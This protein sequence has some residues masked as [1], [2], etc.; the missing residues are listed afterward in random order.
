[1]TIDL[2]LMSVPRI[3]T[4]MSSMIMTTPATDG[5]MTVAGA[6]AGPENAVVDSFLTLLGAASMLTYVRRLLC[7]DAPSPDVHWTGRRYATNLHSFL[8]LHEL[9]AGQAVSQQTDDSEGNAGSRLPT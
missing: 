6:V 1:M 7:S 5:I 3:P 4:L 2:L 8:C 9:S